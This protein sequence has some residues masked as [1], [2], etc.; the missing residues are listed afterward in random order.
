MKEE[1]VHRGQ[2]RILQR[3]VN[4]FIATVKLD[5]LTW[6]F[7]G[8]DSALEHQVDDDAPKRNEKKFN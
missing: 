3:A 2:S 5:I 4:V 8:L 1:T 6:E 7:V